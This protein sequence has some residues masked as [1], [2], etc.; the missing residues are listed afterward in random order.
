MS[1]KPL[2]SDALYAY[3]RL[4]ALQTHQYLTSVSE[5]LSAPC[6]SNNNENTSTHIISQL[7]VS[8]MKMGLFLKRFSI[9][10]ALVILSVLD[11][12]IAYSVSTRSTQYKR[13]RSAHSRLF[14]SWLKSMQNR[15]GTGLL[16]Q[17]VI[18]VI[19]HV[20][21]TVSS[22]LPGVRPEFFR[23][24]QKVPKMQNVHLKC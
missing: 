9:S 15:R 7:R 20:R 22:F 14:Q 17:W 5:P 23:F 21:V 16:G 2:P 19:F 8:L 1:S 3:T 10:P 13:P 6:F 24:S 4:H 18:W 11:L 12:Y